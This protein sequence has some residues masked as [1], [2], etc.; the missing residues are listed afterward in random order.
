MLRAVVPVQHSVSCGHRLLWAR[1]ICRPFCAIALHSQSYVFAI[2]AR[3]HK[4]HF[5]TRFPS[6]TRI[7]RCIQTNSK[8]ANTHR[9]SPKI[10]TITDVS[11]SDIFAYKAQRW[12]WNEPSQ[13]Q[14]RYLKFNIAPLIHAAE[15]ALG[16]GAK[17][18]EMT[19]LPEG[20]FNKTLLLEMED[21]REVIAKLPNPN[22]GRPYY[23]TASEVATMDYVCSL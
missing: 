19:K 9:H 12:L 10:S 13:L 18:V 20:N 1:S 6:A 15:K 14:R 16:H 21:G 8:S 2:G 3:F 5:S 23:T 22:A 17:C 4:R 7:E 11:E